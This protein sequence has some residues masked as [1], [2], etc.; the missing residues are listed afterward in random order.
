[1]SSIF[2]WA[3]DGIILLTFLINFVYQST[4]MKINKQGLCRRYGRLVL[5]ITLHFAFRQFFLGFIQFFTY[6]IARKQDNFLLR[7][8][9]SL[10]KWKKPKVVSVADMAKWLRRTETIFV[11]SVRPSPFFYALSDTIL[12]A[13]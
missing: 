5:P 9:S 8:S 1:M 4:D 7:F 12:S 2:L 10:A 11:F 3:T 6:S 13:L